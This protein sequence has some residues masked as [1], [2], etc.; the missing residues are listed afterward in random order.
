[1]VS[2]RI[3]WIICALVFLL[4]LIPISISLSRKYK[5]YT[6]GELITVTI[7]S[8]P[9]NSGTKSKGLLS[10][11]YNGQNKNMMITG[12]VDDIYHIGDKIKLRHL[13]GYFMS[14]SENPIPSG[15]CAIIFMLLGVI[16]SVYYL[17]NLPT[18]R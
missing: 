13:N 18:T 9:N 4:L 7:T 12:P 16:G 8:I 17:F 1:M 15:I 6:N 5:V 10:F 14:P 2:Y 11:V 3:T